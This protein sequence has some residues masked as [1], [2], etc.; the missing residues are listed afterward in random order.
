MI[1]PSF[2]IG[3]IL[4]SLIEHSYY[5]REGGEQRAVLSFPAAIA[6]TKCLIVPISNNEEFN[7][8]LQQCVTGLRKYGISN[9]VDNSSVSIGRRYSRNDELGTHFGV[10]VDF[11]TLKD[12][13]VT[14]RE[15]DSTKQIR[16]SI[17]V[18]LDVIRELVEERLSWDQVLEKYPL[19]V[20]Q[21]LE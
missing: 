4:Y 17:T 20:Q 8:Y 6:P 14:L 21:E 12:N 15:R 16:E 19:F 10:T 18:V 9:K 3:R 7:P 11:Q 13:T 2:G 5:V 1:E